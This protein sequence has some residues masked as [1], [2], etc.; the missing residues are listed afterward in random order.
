MGAAIYNRGG[1][2]AQRTPMLGKFGPMRIA[3]VVAAS[4]GLL[5]ALAP[6]AAAEPI[7]D[8]LAP[9]FPKF[10]GAPASPDQLATRARRA[11]RSWRR[12]RAATSTTT[13]G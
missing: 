13:R 12:T 4:A 6:G 1:L 3:G 7:V 10:Q 5:L 11:T 8:P 9:L 2:P